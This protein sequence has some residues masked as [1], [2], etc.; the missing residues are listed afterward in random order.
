MVGLLSR[1]GFTFVAEQVTF[2]R[3]GWVNCVELGLVCVGI[4]AEVAREFCF[5]L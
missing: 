5:G 4:G 2:K 3:L 1:L